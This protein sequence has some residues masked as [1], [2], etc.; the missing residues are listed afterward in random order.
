MDMTMDAGLHPA[1]IA[2]RSGDDAAR[3][4]PRLPHPHWSGDGGPGAGKKRR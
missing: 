4:D 2:A 1:T 3:T